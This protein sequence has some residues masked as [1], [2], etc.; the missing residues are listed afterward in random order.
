MPRGNNEKA[1]SKFY[2]LAIS[3]HTGV[4]MSIV[5]IHIKNGIVEKI[6]GNGAYVFVHDHDIPQTTTMI[7]KQQE[8]IYEHNKNTR[9]PDN[10]S[11]ESHKKQRKIGSRISF[12]NNE[13]V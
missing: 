10:E 7:F 13:H 6:E 1:K 11:M 3:P 12:D 5:E 8:E 2:G 9:H 4:T